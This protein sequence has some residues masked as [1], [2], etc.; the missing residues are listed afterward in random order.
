MSFN[1][2]DTVVTPESSVQ[3]AL[4]KLNQTGSR[5]VL[6]C[7]NN[8]LHG[9]VTD[10]DIRRSLL[11]GQGL[12]APV[13]QVMNDK[14]LTLGKQVPRSEALRLMREKQVLAIPIVSDVNELLGLYT[15][16]ELSTSK[17]IDNPVFIMA[18]GFGTRLRPLTN[19]TPKPMLN[20]GGKPVLETLIL[21]LKRHGFVN[22]HISTHYLPEVIH[23][24]FGDGQQFGVSIQY[25]HE[26]S[27]LGT[28]GA[29][30]LLDPEHLKL[31]MLVV[32]GDILT[33][34]DFERLLEFHLQNN[35]A[36]TMCVREYE[37]QIP[38]GVIQGEQG[39]ICSI[40]EKPTQRCFVNAG[41][42]VL[43]PEVIDACVSGAHIDMTD[44]LATQMQNQQ[45]VG[46]F[47]IHEYWLDIGRMDD[48]Q[49]AQSDI[50][51]LGL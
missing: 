24:H 8:R 50:E 38:Y 34:I 14:P 7:Q 45:G 15:L 23:Q 25:V 16:A 40:E 32:N 20:V 10:G 22:F 36:A 6:V 18:G 42:Y 39:R 30:G 29:L 46:M 37:H 19:I 31:P 11:A 9:V 49:R 28:A 33:A 26:E 12:D 13:S 27:P 44:L 21:R 48:F 51:S 1:W 2:V 17:S 41:M 47:P 43:N 5:I 35:F 3:Q 4:V